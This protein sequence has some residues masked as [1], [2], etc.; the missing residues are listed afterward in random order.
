MPE[1]DDVS[2]LNMSHFEEL[3]RRINARL[4]EIG[5]T[6]ARRQIEEFPWLYGALGEVPS[7]AMLICENPSL[8]GVEKAN[9]HTIRAGGPSIEDQWCG[10]P[11][12]NC[13]KRLRPALYEAGLRTK[14][15]QEP[16]GWRCYIT[17][18]IKEA[19]RVKDFAERDKYSPAR[20]WADILAWEFEQVQPTIL[21][22]LGGSATELVTWLQAH[23]HIPSSPKPRRVVHY[24]DRGRNATDENVRTQ[25]LEAFRAGLAATPSFR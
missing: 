5:A 8:G 9:R 11:K 2:D 22:T 20:Q 19:D 12:G 1:H 3:R 4:R 25:M 10:N 14:R 15:P 17:N 16:G 6:H 24:S 21:F 7:R 13:I 18:V 23:G